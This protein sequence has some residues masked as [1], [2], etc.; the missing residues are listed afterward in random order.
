MAY[1]ACVHIALVMNAAWGVKTLRSDLIRFLQSLRHDVSVISR[2]DQAVIDLQRMGVTFED[3]AVARNGLN[4]FREGLAILRLRRLLA[5]IRPDVILCFT[6]KAILLGSL[7]ARATPSSHIFSVFTGLGFLF[8]DDNSPK[9]VLAP[10]IR[11]MFRRSL[12]N[13]HIVFFQ[14]PDDLKMFVTHRIVPVDRTCRLYGS[15]VDTK[16]F[17]PSPSR[18]E[19]DETVFLM[20]ARL[21]AA[22]GVLD[23]IKAATILKRKRCRARFRLLGPFDDHPTA[24]NRDTIQSAAD[25]GIVEYCGTTNDVLPYLH[26]ADVFVLPSYYREGTPRSS[27]EALATAK[28]IITTDSPGCRETVVHDSN[29]YLVPVRD[30]TALAEA[31]RKLVADRDQIRTM[32][33]RSRKLAE[34]LYDVDKVNAH[35]WRE[36][37]KIL[38]PLTSTRTR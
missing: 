25:S 8:G 18:K 21:I 3:W 20:I 12:R 19:R 28:P 7:A 1:Y 4:P 27:L 16:R 13:N 23:Y 5:R 37:G 34:E 29:G 10:I 38:T 22:K 32:G 15:G 31:M 30:P 24:V 2:A 36:I 35:L 11:F 9:R 26:D 6:P 14:N 17:V 33:T